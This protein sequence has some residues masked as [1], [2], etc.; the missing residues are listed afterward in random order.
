MIKLIISTFITIFLAELGDKTQIATMMLAANSKQK[1]VIFIGS[2]L[3]LVCSSLVAVLL[4]DKLN[5][6]IPAEYIQKGAAIA[7]ITVGIL[8]LFNKI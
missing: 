5:R 6:L 8:L 7:F 4:G 3:A 1:I 2:S